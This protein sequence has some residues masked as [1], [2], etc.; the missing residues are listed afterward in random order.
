MPA[1]F[2]FPF[3]LYEIKGE[4]KNN[5]RGATGIQSYISKYLK[6]FICSY[7]SLLESELPFILTYGFV[8]FISEYVPKLYKYLG[9]SSG[10]FFP[11]KKHIL[12]PQLKKFFITEKCCRKLRQL[13]QYINI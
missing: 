5:N 4:G 8:D 12:V 10:N 7:V 13:M 9:N 2:G 6:I 1:Q 3:F 11:K